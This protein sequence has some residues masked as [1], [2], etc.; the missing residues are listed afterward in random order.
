MVSLLDKVKFFCV[1]GV[2]L[3]SDG[4]LNLTIGLVVPMLG[5]L[6]WQ[7]QGGEVPSVQSDIMKGTLNVGMAV[8]Q[9]LFGV[10]GDALGRHKVY[11][12]ELLI[13]LFGTLMVILLPWNNFDQ[14]SIV[15]WVACFRVVTGIGIGADYP[16]SSSLTAESTPLGSRAVLSL[17]VFACMGLGNIAA[18]ITFLVLVEA[19]QSGIESDI[20]YV[21]WVW[22]LLFG[23]GMIPAAITLYARWTMAETAPYEKYVSKATRTDTEQTDKRGL[24]EQFRDFAVYFSEWKHAKV[25]FATSAS[26][27]LF[28]IAYYGVNLNQ[29]V[30]LKEIGFADGATPW[31]TLRNT[32]IGN[33]IV[34]VAGYLP[35]YFCGIPLPDLLGRTHQQFYTCMIVAILY[36]IWA[37]ITNHTSVGGL[38]TVFT[39]SQL[40]L[41]MG[42]DCTT[43]LMPVEVF[44]TCVRGTA[45][46]ISA[47][48]GKLG[49]ILTAFAFGTVTD[50]IGLPGVLGLFSGVMVLNAL[51]TFLIPETRGMTIADIE[52]EVHFAEHRPMDIFKWPG[53]WKKENEEV[54]KEELDTDDNEPSKSVGVFP[55]KDVSV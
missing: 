46:G 1:A 52:N 26:W 55:N 15:A 40:F 38:M 48:A 10:L 36:A 31:L 41:N 54:E 47:A 16:M 34:Q 27:F 18:S 13:T 5:Y 30:I 28:D 9:L 19:F 43:W 4:F 6:Y 14:Q 53:L 11:G 8:G 37:G 3:F 32:A 45:H 20:Q 22:R 49:A 7:D 50:R 39:L 17:S 25:L 12:K 44:P 2:G 29:S 35:G 23:L 21:E 51:V 24:R 42:P 33:I